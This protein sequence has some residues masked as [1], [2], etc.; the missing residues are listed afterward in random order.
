MTLRQ[1]SQPMPGG[2]SSS[3]GLLMPLVGSG[4]LDAGQFISMGAMCRESRSLMISM[5]AGTRPASIRAGWIP[6]FCNLR[7]G[8]RLRGRLSGESFFPRR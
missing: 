3:T 2:G 1:P 8:E 5:R 6:C 7:T 4:E